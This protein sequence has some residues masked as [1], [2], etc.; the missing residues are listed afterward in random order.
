M[1]IT[2]ITVAS[3]APVLQC[4][5]V[6]GPETRNALGG[7]LSI[8]KVWVD[9]RGT[10]WPH[11]FTLVTLDSVVEYGLQSGALESSHVSPVIPK[12]GIAQY[13]RYELG[14][15]VSESWC[16]PATSSLGGF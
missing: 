11:P 8:G 16:F 9:W 4:G 15:K 14:V 10:L 7:A 12:D 3:A 5:T 1:L 6:V 2:T 13:K